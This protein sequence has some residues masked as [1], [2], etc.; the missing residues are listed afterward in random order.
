MG[1][2]AQR[3]GLSCRSVGDA[4]WVEQYGVFG[5]LLPILIPDRQAFF[6]LPVVNASLND[7]LPRWSVGGYHKLV[8]LCRYLSGFPG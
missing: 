3:R 5:E 7:V 6:G 4:Y 8:L 2:G 1:E